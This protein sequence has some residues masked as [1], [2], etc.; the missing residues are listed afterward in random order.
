M[1]RARTS[2]LNDRVIGLLEEWEE[3]RQAGPEPTAEEL[4]PDD[5]ALRDELKRRIARRRHVVAL[6]DSTSDV[7]DPGLESGRRIGPFHLLEVIGRGG[8]G[9]V[10]RAYHGR[11]RREVAL[12]VIRAEQVGDSHARAR[13]EREMAALGGLDHPRIVKALHADEVDGVLYLAMEKVEGI[14][15]AKLVQRLGPLPVADACELARQAALIL[16]E[17]HRRGFIHRDLKPSN[18]MLT[19][20]GTIVLLDLGLALTDP[21]R[22]DGSPG[23]EEEL[24]L[25]G[26]MLGTPAYMA[27]EQQTEA[28]K[29]D[30]RSDLF[31]LGAML[32]KFLTGRLPKRGCAVEL[33]RSSNMAIPP[34]LAGLL[35]RLMSDRP[36]DRPDSAAE[37]AETLEPFTDGH[38]LPGLT[39]LL[40]RS[41]RV[42]RASVP[43]RP[44]GRERRLL[45][46]GV[47]LVASVALLVA[48]TSW[49][50][51]SRVSA[52]AQR[53]MLLL[54]SPIADLNVSIKR[55]DEIVS[56]PT[57]R[58]GDNFI[59]LKSGDYEVFL[60]PASPRD[61]A[62]DRGRFDL[63]RGG[64]AVVTIVGPGGD[65]RKGTGRSARIKPTFVSQ[66]E[67]PDRTITENRSVLQRTIDGLMSFKLPGPS[68]G[69]FLNLV[70]EDRLYPEGIIEATCRVADGGGRGAWLL[71]IEHKDHHHGALISLFGDG[72]VRIGPSGND[73]SPEAGP[74]ARV[75]TNEDVGRASRWNTVRVV[76]KANMI[77]AYINGRRIAGPVETGFLFA[78]GVISLGAQ[79]T[80]G[81]GVVEVQT[82]RLAFWPT[83]EMDDLPPW[84]KG[85]PA[86]PSPG[87][88]E[89]SFVEDWKRPKFE[90]ITPHRFIVQDGIYAIEVDS[91]RNGTWAWNVCDYADGTIEVRGR[92]AEGSHS[93]WVLNIGKLVGDRDGTGRGASFIVQP[94]GSMKIRTNMFDKDTSKEALNADSI[95]HPSIRPS[96]EWNT[97]RVVVKSNS[98]GA[99]ING[100]PIFGPVAFSKPV[101]PGR[102]CLGVTGPGQGGHGRVEF[103]KLILWPTTNLDLLP[104]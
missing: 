44:H 32:Y 102:I 47:G 73:K 22:A 87:K 92:V 79:R 7:A 84:P 66:W 98:L 55:G 83:T 77:V 6:L 45:R 5:E 57:L 41:A 71:N 52:S 13:F 10:Y 8:M 19:P 34:R 67:G 86:D 23:A 59:D 36:E 30:L 29:A 74:A 20:G 61:L 99:E 81:T 3:R 72:R 25:P 104:R 51:A 63:D 21:A 16:A 56:R 46:L 14:D 24:T 39:S 40:D 35:E 96:G 90:E 76:M 12:K 91:K 65:E 2:V 70:E 54:R 97:L 50:V 78:P 101:T 89:P 94:D 62:P 42:S 103:D 33:S 28:H 100:H 85:P 60:D 27:P 69:T 9:T 93:G 48:A 75:V 11:L 15:L 38:D 82:Q 95:R 64:F 80:D 4:C 26:Q 58:E 37:V 1:T 43:R 53:G 88:I 31:A 49:L 68:S 18:L 17:V